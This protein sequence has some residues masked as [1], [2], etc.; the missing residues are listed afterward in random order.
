MRMLRW[1]YEYTRRDKIRNEVIR[2][3]VGVASLEDKMRESRL[4]WFEH[5]KRRSIE[6]PIRRCERLA[7]ASLKRDRGRPK[8]YWGE[9]IR[10]DMAL[11]QLTKDM[12]LDRRATR[13][14]IRIKETYLRFQEYGWTM[15][16]K[17]P[18]S[19]EGI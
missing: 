8:K 15:S 10:Q 9:V 18:S 12:T 13:L 17:N 3:K 11:I 1:M 7:M 6:P 2:D 19:Q 14:R 4:R 5:V 16:T